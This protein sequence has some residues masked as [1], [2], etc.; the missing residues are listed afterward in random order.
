MNSDD[1]AQVVHRR[2]GKGKE[3]VRIHEDST[4]NSEKSAGESGSA[5][6]DVMKSAMIDV[7][8][9]VMKG[10]NT[11]DSSATVSKW[12]T[13]SDHPT[14]ELDLS[15]LLNVL[16][17]VVDCPGRIVVMTTNHPEKL[18]PALIR[19]DLVNHD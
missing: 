19:W 2:D 4:P 13:G 15:G 18:D 8:K 3:A 11:S 6:A 7:V 17:G 1:D 16:D 5:V 10:E 12:V 9:M 14:D